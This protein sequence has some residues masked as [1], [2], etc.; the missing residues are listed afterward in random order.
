M[1]GSLP[2]T[3]SLIVSN[4]GLGMLY[5]EHMM[6][7]LSYIGREGAVSKDLKNMPDTLHDL[8]KLMLDECRRNRSKDQYE[9]LKRLFAWLAFSR[10]SLSLAEASELVKLTITEN[11]F[12]IEDEIIGRSARILELSRTEPLDEDHPEDVKDDDAEDH[13]DDIVA[14]INE[15]RNAS[16]T[17]QERSL[18]QYFR[19]VSVEAHGEEELRT[20]ASAAHLTI[21]KMCI[22]ILISSADAKDDTASSE[23]KGYAVQYWYE[24][25]KDLDI[26]S[27]SDEDVR[28]VLISVHRIMSNESNVASLFERQ[29]QAAELYPKRDSETTTP[30]Y[31]SLQAWAV[32]GSTIPEDTLSQ[33]VKAWS[34]ELVAN[35]KDAL[36]PLAKAH[37]DNWRLESNRFFIVAAYKFAATALSL[38]SSG[39]LI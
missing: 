28:Q 37:V 9:A 16:L 2:S 12:D 17:F 4:Q 30:W 20:P 15:Y 8:Y 22:D 3:P 39:D 13:G 34:G 33:E 31:D 38:V 21:L 11:D 24:H 10:R 6:R 7:R 14:E 25:L 26:S 1:V 36:L 29:A 35:P 19:A 27:A 23:L 5:V 18:R 32:R